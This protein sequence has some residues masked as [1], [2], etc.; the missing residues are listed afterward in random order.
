MSKRKLSKI[1][2][3]NCVFTPEPVVSAQIGN[4]L[5]EKLSSMKNEVTVI[6][7]RPSRPLG[8]K[9]DQQIYQK[10]AFRL[11]YLR[12][13][14][15]PKSGI[16]GRLLES[17]SF[18]IATYNYIISNAKEIDFVY[19][20]TWP[21]FAQIAITI[22]C[23]RVKKSYSVHMQDIYPESVSSKLPIFIARFLFFLLMP[24]DKFVL[25]NADKIIVISDKM[26][27]D[28]M[29][30]RK[31]NGNKFEVV[32]NWHNEL[33][34]KP[35]QKYWPKSPLTFMYLGN[36]GPVAGLPFV[37]QAFAKA[38]L[39]DAQLII[40]GS[41]SS[42]N[43]CMRMAENYPEYSI[44]FIEVPDGEV[45]AL[46]SKAHVM[47]L[48]LKSKTGNTSIPSKLPAYMF[49]ARPIIALADYGTDVQKI[50]SK[51]DCGWVGNS[52]DELWLINC[53]KQ[54]NTLDHSVLINKG[55]LARKYATTYYSKEVNL[56]KLVKAIL[57]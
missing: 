51:S 42:K 24:I 47:L 46:Q 10:K 40:A 52:E 38:A 7:P 55:K 14:T 17:I 54:V 12:S 16:I 53:F 18:G 37:I 26:K 22:A 2:I 57:D 20:N 15:Y 23:K 31:L 50:I 8:F 13:F 56:D 29:K 27:E 43:S 21:I 9:F 48:P 49:S 5:A 39:N 34:F 6:A 4:S 33:Q 41:G 28:L 19:M 25:K 35:F 1:L 32:L 30:S 36:I 3:V 11:I 44:S 45:P